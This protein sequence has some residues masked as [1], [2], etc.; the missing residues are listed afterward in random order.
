MRIIFSVLCVRLLQANTLNTPSV[1]I[2]H[3]ACCV[4]LCVLCAPNSA[5]SLPES[6]YP[7]WDSLPE[8]VVKE[9]KLSRYVRPALACAT[10]AGETSF[11]EPF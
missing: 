5:I 6:K 4:V 7:L 10:R 11:T 2:F 8:D 9:G 1:L 3:C